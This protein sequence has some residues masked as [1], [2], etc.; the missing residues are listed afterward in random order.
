MCVGE[1]DFQERGRAQGRE[2]RRE[3]AQNE[4]HKKQR[5]SR[6]AN[7]GPPHREHRIAEHV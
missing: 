5:T 3:R 6:I 7:I 2:G 1:E 4:P